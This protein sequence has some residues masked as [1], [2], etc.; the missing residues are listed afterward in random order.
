MKQNSKRF[1]QLSR[2]NVC[3]ESAELSVLSTSELAETWQMRLQGGFLGNV[4][5][6]G[7]MN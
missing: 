7:F 3:L 4:D 1:A 5:R 2:E 6:K